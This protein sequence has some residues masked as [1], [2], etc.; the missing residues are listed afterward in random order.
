MF[1]K[2]YYKVSAG[3]LRQKQSV[4]SS[5]IP[6]PSA[7]DSSLTKPASAPAKSKVQPIPFNQYGTNIPQSEAFA[8]DAD[9]ARPNTD[10]NVEASEHGT[11]IVLSEDDSPP[12]QPD[13]DKIQKLTPAEHTELGWESPPGWDYDNETIAARIAKL[14][15]KRDGEVENPTVSPAQT[16]ASPAA[17]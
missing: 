5:S 6:L 16:M 15:K 13:V 9:R 11:P 7:V 14:M 1:K 17:R 2:G 8:V 12:P 3:K 10:C 4:G